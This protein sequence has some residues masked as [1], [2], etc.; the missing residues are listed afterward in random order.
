MTHCI[1]KLSETSEEVRSKSRVISDTLGIP[2]LVADLMVQRG[3]RNTD[4]AEAF[5]RADLSGLED[6]FL[7]PDMEKAVSRLIQ[8][9]EDGE[10][11]RVYGDYDVDGITS[12]CVVMDVL[13][14]LGAEVDYYIPDRVDEGYGVNPEAVA[15]I[16]EDGVSLLITVDCGVTASSE[17]EL[18]H[19]LGMDVII[20]DHH[21]PHGE[22]PGAVAVINPKCDSGQYPFR[23]LA[24]VGVAYKLVQALLMAIKGTPDAVNP[25]GRLLDLVAL[26]T[27]A[28]VCPL[29]G[30]NRIY[31][32]QGLAQ[33]NRTENLGLKA[34]IDVCGLT[35][36][37]ISAGT[38]GFV[39]APR[40]NAAGR[41]GDVSLCIELLTTASPKRAM[42]IAQF[43]NQ[44]NVQR[45]TLEQQIFDEASSMVETYDGEAVDS[46]LV[47][48]NEGWHPGVIGIVAS[49]LVEQFNRPTIVISLDGDEGRGSGRSIPEFDLYKGLTE[50]RGTLLRFGGHKHAAGIAISRDMIDVF[51]HEIN[52]VGRSVLRE[53]D[54]VPKILCHQEVTLDAIDLEVAKGIA[55]LAPFGVANPTPLLLS[56]EVGLLEYRGVGASGRHLKL[57]LFQNGVVHDGIG[58]GLGHLASE[59]YSRRIREIDLVY[60]IEVNE[61]NGTIQPQLNVKGMRATESRA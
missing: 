52:E 46:V 16:A 19:S 4:D 27:I 14:S 22:L 11:I 29:T 8:A 40:L 35:G 1:W 37:K 10:K 39:V 44:V 50:C 5:L 28:D 26:G 57:K 43:L 15:G 53:D 13:N 42:E 47:L 31:A 7:L 12:I 23:D 18:A 48:A 20:T 17:V 60:S 24:G 34:L 9:I 58:F 59:L 55:M 33:M 54:F 49:R 51:R 6:P 21:E 61:W 30:E 56:T 25:P 45:Q 2:L 36:R 3:V 32:K 41:I 38:V